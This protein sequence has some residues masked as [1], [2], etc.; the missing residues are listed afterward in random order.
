MSILVAEVKK[1]MEDADQRA[2]YQKWVTNPFTQRIHQ[3]ARRMARPS[4]PAPGEHHAVE[5]VAAVHSATAANLILDF[6]FELDALAVQMQDRQATETYD[7]DAAMYD[8]GYGKTAPEKPAAP[9]IAEEQRAGRK[10]T[11]RVVKPRQGDGR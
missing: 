1:L 2:A 7:M 11:A 9:V 3:L 8:W 4:A 10:R 6:M 5:C